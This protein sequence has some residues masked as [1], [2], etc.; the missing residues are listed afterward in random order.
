MVNVSLSTQMILE[1]E[2]WVVKF[3]KKH[4]KSAVI[5]ALTIVQR[6]NNGWLNN[7]LLN[8]VAEYLELPTIA[9]Y[10][11]ATFYSMFELQPVGKY[12]ICVCTNISCMLCGG[13]TVANHLKNK[14][15]IN[16]GEITNDGKF[17][18]KEIECIAACD[19]APVVEINGKQFKNVTVESVDEILVNLE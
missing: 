8:A 5:A 13:V 1:I 2:E 14:L 17:S 10:E 7:E 4:K 12:K 3:P 11:V 9:V 18:L 16:F 6:Y 19:H 15:N